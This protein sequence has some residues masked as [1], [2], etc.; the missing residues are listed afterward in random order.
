M[1]PANFP[2][3]NG[4]MNAGV[5][6]PGQMQG[7]PRQ[8]FQHVLNSVAHALG[9]QGPFT[10]WRAEVS[11][12]DR[13]FKVHQMIT[14]LRLISPQIEV[15]N[16]ASAAMSFEQK[17][18]KEAATKADYEREF[19]DKL[20]H[21]RDSRA[22]QAAAMQGGVMQQG[23][24]TGM[25]GVGQAPFPPQMSQRMQAS[26]MAGQQQMQMGM[27]DLN[28][29]A[30]MQQRQQQQQQQQQQPQAML[31]QQ[32]PQP[33]PGGAAA[34]N[35]ELHTLSAPEYE[36]V[37]RIAN[38]IAAK[39]SEEDMNKI[40]A[41]LANMSQEQRVYLQK[42]SMDPITYFFRCQA[43]SHIRRVKRSRMEMNRNN[44]N[45]GVDAANALMGDSMANS[46][47]Q[48]QMFQNMMM[49]QRNP[50]FSMG[51]QQNLDPSSFI[52]N[53]E[54]I[55]GQQADG[56]RSQE[57][58]HLVVPASSSQM[59]QQ[60]FNATPN[61]LPGG[62]QLSQAHQV[63]M[64]NAGIS[65]PFMAQQHLP[66]SQASLPDR[67][68]Q[69]AQFQ[70]QPSAQTQ[71][72]RI[73]AAQ[74]AQLA[75]SQANSHMQPMSQSPAMPMINRPMAAPGQMSPARV[76][77]Q[78]QTPARQAGMGQ[79]QPNG[80]P[81]GAQQ[82]MA[83]RP[84]I[85]AHLPPH[86]QEQL[87][88][89]SNEQL[90]AFF[91][92]RGH[93]LRNNPMLTR[94]NQ[95]NMAMQQ[96]IP[97]VN[98][99]QQMVNGQMV[100]PQS[101]RASLDLQQ[102]L[103]SMGGTQP[104]NQMLSGQQMSVQQRQQQQHQQQ[105]R[106]LQLLRQHTAPGAELNAEQTAQMDR[107]PYPSAIFNNNPNVAAAIPKDVKSWG[108]LK[109]LAATNPQA[110]GGMDLQKLS[111]FQKYHFAQILKETSNRNLQQQQSS[112]VP[113]DAANLQGQPQQL[114][115][116]Q[117]F[118]PGLQQPQISVPQMR[119]I[120]QQELQVA[121][122]RLGA[123]VQNLTDDQLREAL[124]QRHLRHQAAQ[125]MVNQQN[126]QSQAQSQ[127][128]VS[129]PP[130][131]PHVKTEPQGQHQPP[132]QNIQTQM[133]KAQAAAAAK[134]A[135]APATKQTPPTS[136]RKVPNEESAV[137]QVSPVQSS[138][139]PAASQGLPAT[140][141]P[142]PNMQITRE[143]LAS[144]N[145]QQRAQF[146]AQL[147]MRRQQGQ[148]RGPVNRAAAEDAWNNLP[149]SI[150]H[151]Y[152]ELAK[153]APADNPVAVTDE[154]RA[155]MNQQLRDC[156]DYLGRMDA[157][158]QFI[159]KI[160]GH[161]KNVR[162]LLGMRI[163]LMRQYKPGPDWTLNDHVTIT[164]E[165]LRG[166]TN[167]IKKLF[168]HM[169]ARVNQQQSQ[170]PGQRPGASQPT[171]AQQSKQNMALNASNL[172]QLQQQEEAL[173]RA[174]RASSQTAASGASA[175]A[176]APFG[177][178]SPQGVPHAY[179]PGGI[180]PQEL[181][182]PPPKKRKQSHPSTT[183]VSGPS[184]LKA[185]PTKQAPTEAKPVIGAF[186][187][188]VPECQYHYQGFTT[189]ND[190]DK[191]V[192][193]SHKVEE[194]IEDA[195]EFALQSFSTLLQSEQKADTQDLTNGFGFAVDV[196]PNKPGST[197]FPAKEVKTEGITPAPGAT[198][199][200][201]VS[202]Q[203]AAKPASPASKVAG[204]SSMKPA[205][206]RDGKPEPRKSAEQESASLAASTKDAW[207]DSKISLDTIRD[208]FDLDFDSALG[209]GAMDEFLN[210]EMFNGTQNT[211][212]SVET[213]VV[214]QTPK[215]VDMLKSEEVASKDSSVTE[216]GWI[217]TD[218]YCLPGQFE[219]GILMNES[220][221]DI[222]WEMVDFKDGT[223]NGDD[224]SMAIFAV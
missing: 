66:N 160:P 119:P 96:N 143:Q 189:Q 163:Q 85:P 105:L 54:N 153:N 56:L 61:M 125:A 169:I 19:N 82:G 76:A 86:I 158:V 103:A 25:A 200:G 209:F 149:E 164:P 148:A 46:Q 183:P 142:R 208:G 108:Q 13:T 165:Y 220:C 206:S 90:T 222:D 57:A 20:V 68:Q 138:T 17:A 194:P 174:R 215:D 104:P 162:S 133:A 97:Q 45:N 139:Q 170:A 213:G 7:I 5:K 72:Q 140:A 173:Q 51:N 80:Q 59:N 159:N 178:P 207:A 34:L 116:P 98:P 37:C 21:I 67:T 53:V 218:W 224:N 52:G 22:R 150:R 43:M 58:G 2:N 30:A 202:S 141:P 135:K 100:N 115:N 101:I 23:H 219:D 136:K 197:P 131:V 184:G 9:T 50:S 15:R 152:N 60:P 132:Q 87:S 106:G 63:N 29:Q 123:Q 157:L 39:T 73:Q 113:W 89:L 95:Q 217:P 210:V 3:V 1:N 182:L 110:L 195:L 31:Q 137:T 102:Q 186:K 117:Q 211:P 201:R 109:R 4:V 88:R 91:M 26:P 35:D 216:S 40:K 212:D 74:K 122:Q 41:N 112:Q 205:P 65:P 84:Q 44:Q 214:T 69:A 124:R 93:M 198:P 221:E 83:N 10:G 155:T 71:A 126:Q 128:P 12:R 151:L 129:V 190:L 79:P 203:M 11:V 144:M 180:P 78:V 172:Q 176:P 181:K 24:P 111:T 145:P 156:T 179:G 16:A 167:Y 70:S 62:Q 193:D 64:N 18:F 146:E 77:A 27:N 147:Q 185:P 75:M 120:T 38:Q 161:E 175:I 36:N 223:M 47:Q 48:R 33:R 55:Q 191:H 99:G 8:D 177:A 114:L 204:S 28:Q 154:Q 94:A 32:R 42:K 127:P 187:C 199:M 171:N 188:S 49:Q 192:E 81:M 196:T 14:S 6:P 134:P 166:T 92:N 107:M 121:R 118:Q 130:T 168:H